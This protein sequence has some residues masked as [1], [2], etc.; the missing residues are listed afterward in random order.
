MA[1]RGST[2][3]IFAHLFAALALAASFAA[4]PAR[5]LDK[6]TFATNWLAE[7]EHGGFYQAK[8]DG[9][10]EKYGL[11]VTILQGGPNANN[12]LLLAAGKKSN[13]ALAPI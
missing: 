10:Y 9:T 3:K 4:A 5:A 2:L 6:V 13:S 11:D 8:A 1:D 7:A 12:R